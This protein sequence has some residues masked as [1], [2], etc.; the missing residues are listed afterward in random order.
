MTNVQRVK[1]ER[2]AVGALSRAALR[3]LVQPK[4]REKGS[5]SE[6]GSRGLRE[7]IDLIRVELNEVEQ[8]IDKGEGLARVNE[9]L[10]DVAAF[11][12]IALDLNGAACCCNGD[13]HVHH[14]AGYFVNEETRRLER[15]DDCATFASDADVERFLGVIEATSIGADDVGNLDDVVGKVEP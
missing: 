3:R 13:E 10:G 14:C 2:R 15:C 11:V 7:V 5:W 8:A 12:A 6:L 9:E 1:D 4:N